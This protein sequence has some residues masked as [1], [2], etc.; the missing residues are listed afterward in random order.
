MDL[1]FCVGY[2]KPNVTMKDCFLL[3]RIH[4]TLNML[5]GAKWFSTLD[6]KSSYWRV[7]LHPDN[8]KKTVFSTG[9]GLW[10]FMVRLFG[11]CNAPAMFELLMKPS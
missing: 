6:L 2:G 5:T 9:Q 7:A 1:H 11:L 8:R 3:L 4:D 10:Q